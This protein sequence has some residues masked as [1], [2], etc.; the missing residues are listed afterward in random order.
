MSKKLGPTLDELKSVFNKAIED[1]QTNVEQIVVSV[2]REGFEA[3]KASTVDE[4]ETKLN[5]VKRHAE[6]GE[7]FIVTKPDCTFGDYEKGDVFT[8]LEH[9]GDG[10]VAKELREKLGESDEPYIRHSEYEVII[11]DEVPLQDV[12]T[13]EPVPIKSPN[14]QR[15][16][17]NQQAREFV[18]NHLNAEGLV[19]NH[20]Y[21]ENP[22]I[23]FFR[24][25]NKT[26]CVITPQ[27]TM[28]D[29]FVGRSFC[30]KGDVF[31]EWIG[32]AIALAR[33][34]EIDIPQEFIDAVQPTE[35]VKG[36]VIRYHHFTHP[37]KGKT[38][39]IESVG[40][41]KLDFVCGSFYPFVGVSTVKPKIIDDTNAIYGTD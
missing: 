34:L 30:S 19:I 29:R 40:I 17:L 25:G 37:Q 8:A 35:Y 27:N 23:S 14:Q 2:Y 16:E 15:K 20:D 18:E 5:T 3:G 41:D 39:E 1:I 38:R 24:K 4:P 26:T 32:K 13:K 36:Q 12:P 21:Y 6:I 9:F 7:R 11:E 28:L 10:V 33:A 22:T 31:N